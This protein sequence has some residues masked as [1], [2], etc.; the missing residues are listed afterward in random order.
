MNH[1][2]AG[3]S[4]WFIGSST[5]LVQPMTRPGTGYNRFAMENRLITQNLLTITFPLKHVNARNFE[6]IRAPFLKTNP[7][8]IWTP[9][10]RHRAE[11]SQHGFNE[12]LQLWEKP[13]GCKGPGKKRGGNRRKN[14]PVNHHSPYDM[15][16]EKI[17]FTYPIFQKHPNMLR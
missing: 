7:Q 12:Y 10:P 6:G 9:M 11:G 4:S 2:A 14:L 3:A 1:Q 16:S 8:A 17:G 15:N 13:A 5:H